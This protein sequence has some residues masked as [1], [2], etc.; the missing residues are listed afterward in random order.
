MTDLPGFLNSPVEGVPL[1]ARPVYWDPDLPVATNENVINR[2]IGHYRDRL[3]AGAVIDEAAIMVPGPAEK[4]RLARVLEPMGWER[5]NEAK[6]LVYTNPFGTRYFVEYMFFRKPGV[7]YRLEVM[8][9]GEG[10]IDGESGFSPLHAALM[11]A[12]D[13]EGSLRFPLPHLSFKV[14]PGMTYGQAV[15][16]LKAQACIHAQTCQ[17]TYGH[18]GYYLGNDAARQIY[19]KPRVNTRDGVR[20]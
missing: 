19:L 2:W 5:F 17:S 4:Y 18:F 11:R 9:M 7:P 3:P 1:A 12:D 15:D 8:H 20:A 13:F 14:P 10:R 6:D 16:H